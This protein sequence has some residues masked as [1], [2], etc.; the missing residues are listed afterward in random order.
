MKTFSIKVGSEGKGKELYAYLAKMK[1]NSGKNPLDVIT[2]LFNGDKSESESEEILL[3]NLNLDSSTKLEKYG[4]KTESQLV[5]EMFLDE[6]G[7]N[8]NLD[9]LKKCIVAMAKADFSRA[10]S[11]TQWHNKED[12]QAKIHSMVTAQMMKNDSIHDDK[13]FERELINS[14][15]ISVNCK[16]SMINADEYLLGYKKEVDEH[17]QKIRT[18]DGKDLGRYFNR[19]ARAAQ[20]KTTP[21]ATPQAEVP[22]TAAPQESEE[23][24]TNDDEILGADGQPL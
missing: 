14:K 6:N 8:F 7:Q 17:N 18:V 3:S 10:E 2:D 24:Q 21:Q 19:S 13:W 22:Q 20:R 15:W 9:M 4:D 1:A 12:K 5:A 11:G 23:V 16:T